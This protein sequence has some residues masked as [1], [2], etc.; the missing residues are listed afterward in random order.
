MRGISVKLRLQ[1]EKSGMTAKELA[2][3]AGCS[4]ALIRNI[5]DG[6]YDMSKLKLGTAAAIANALDKTIDD[7]FTEEVS[8]SSKRTA[9]RIFTTG[10]VR[11]PAAGSLM[12]EKGMTALYENDLY[13]ADDKCY[14]TLET[15][16]SALAEYYSQMIGPMIIWGRN[17]RVY[18]VKEY[19][20]GSIIVDD[21]G[22]EN[23]CGERIYAE[24]K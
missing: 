19:F 15:A 12:P 23:L 24:Y 7:V 4:A 22:R 17:K 18:E 20:I 21:F 9:Y 6:T 16:R 8:E 2:D 1:R 13:L 5:E 11:I 10:F 3:K 14:D